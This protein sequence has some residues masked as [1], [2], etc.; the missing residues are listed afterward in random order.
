MLDHL[1]LEAEAR[2]VERAIAETTAAGILT[3]EL[4][5]R[6]TTAEVGDA[7]RDRLRLDEVS[8]L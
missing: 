1:G 4:G 8:S 2:A 7:I 5:G 3:P 6:A